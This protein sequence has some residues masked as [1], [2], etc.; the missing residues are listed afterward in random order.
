MSWMEKL[1]QTYE[2]GVLL[3]LPQTQL[4]MPT[5]HTLQNAH[6]NI[7]IDGEGNFKGASVL[8]KTQIVLPAT[9]DSA[10]RSSNE[11][12]HG[13]A[14]KLQYVAQ[15]YAS[16]GGKKKPYFESY[17]KQLQTWCKSAHS[18]DKVKAVYRYIEKGTVIKDLLAHHIVFVDSNNILLTQW[19]S[20]D[21]EQPKLFKVLPKE[22]GTL[23][24]GSALVCW[25]VEK[26]SDPSADTWKDKSIPCLSGCRTHLLDLVGSDVNTDV[27]YTTYAGWVRQPDRHSLFKPAGLPT[28]HQTSVMR[29]YAT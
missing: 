25:T 9:E 4:P 26:A 16:Y 11:A 22:K 27:L 21:G 6:I 23:D 5:S 17:K 10:S 24:Q 20:D 12:P 18:H 28:T 2:A 8:E 13:L 19:N 29:V 15:D 14:D 3:G 7:V 1:Y